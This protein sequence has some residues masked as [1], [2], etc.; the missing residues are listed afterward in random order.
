MH[1]APIDRSRLINR[2]LGVVR[3][4]MSLDGLHS[5]VG[6]LMH[7]DAINNRQSVVGVTNV[8]YQ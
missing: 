5:A 4:I 8:T 1:G 3:I 2:Y 7:F 6:N